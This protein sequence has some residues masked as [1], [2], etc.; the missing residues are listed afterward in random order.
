MKHKN[1][2]VTNRLRRMI[3]E[4]V[5]KVIKEDEY[6][7]EGKYTSAYAK[8]ENQWLYRC[9]SELSYDEVFTNFLECG[10]SR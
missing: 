1:K 8:G 7:L 10:V 3:D 4:T 9:L 5:R 2:F 6:E